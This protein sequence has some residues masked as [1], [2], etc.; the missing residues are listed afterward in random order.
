MLTIDFETE[1]IDG[2]PVYNP[3]RPVGVSIKLGD[4]PSKYWAWGHPTGNNCTPAE[5][6][7][8]LLSALEH[9]ARGVP[10]LAHNS[11]FEASIL[12]QFYGWECPDPL[13]FHDTQYSLFLTDPYAFSFSLKP[14]AERILGLPPDER[15]EVRDWLLAHQPMKHKG[16]TIVD[17]KTETEARHP[18]GRYICLAPGDLVGKYAEGDT[19]RTYLLHQKCYP[20]VVESGQLAAYQRE[21]RLM[22]IL[23]ESTRRGVRLDMGRLEQD[24]ERYRAAQKVS[25]DYIFSRLGEFDLAKDAELAAALD[26][27]GQVTEWVLTPTGRRSVSRKNLVGRVRDPEILAHLAYRGV[28]ETCLGTFAAPWLGQARR[29]CGRLHP[30]WNQVRG[31]RGADGDLSGTRTGRMSCRA[32]NLQNPP[33]DFEELVVP[34]G[35]PPMMHMRSYLLPEEGMIWLKRDFSAQEMRI[36]AHYTE[37]ALAQAFRNDPSTDP[38]EAVKV[39]IKEKGGVDLSRKFVKITGFGIMYGRGVPN[40]SAALGVD[41]ERG[42][43]T[44]DAYYAALPEVRELSNETRQRGRRGGFITTWGGRRYF[45]EPNEERDLSYKLLNYLI[46]GSAADQTKQAII[47]WHAL[48]KPTDLLIAAVHDELNICAPA[49]ETDAAM[50][51]LQTA[52]DWPRFDVPFQSEGYRGPNW[53]D[54]VKE[55]AK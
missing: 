23:C 29:E 19:D 18:W 54:I 16:I 35:Q 21:Q 51:R 10:L 43:A 17:S 44:R 5:G 8:A 27:A 38:H 31:D 13:L 15:D 32:P 2:N 45:R 40:L 7:A 11:P 26:R 50:Y 48:R 47:D 9:V 55:K 33:N 49:E 12:R 39:I 20:Q 53:A 25:D 34:A 6:R 30:Q 41:V 52:M 1:G 24:I 14:S 42:K 4:A 28:L 36:L 3:P 46:Q 37:G 22:P